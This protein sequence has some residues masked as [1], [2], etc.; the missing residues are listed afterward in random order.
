[1]FIDD[2]FVIAK[3]EIYFVVYLLIQINLYIYEYNPALKMHLNYIKIDYL[4]YIILIEVT[5][6]GTNI[7]S[8]VCNEANDIW[9]YM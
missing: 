2:L 6:S 5:I 8:H 3:I 4:N 9:R 1:M 7:L